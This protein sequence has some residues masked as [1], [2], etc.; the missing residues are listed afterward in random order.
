MNVKR[1]TLFGFFAVLMALMPITDVMAANLSPPQQA[2]EIASDKI[3]GKN[4]G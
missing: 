2:I 3:T 4:A 1:Y